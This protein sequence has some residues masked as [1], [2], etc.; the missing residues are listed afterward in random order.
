[1]YLTYR[2]LAQRLKEERHSHYSMLQKR[3]KTQWK[4]ISFKEGVPGR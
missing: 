1:M 3:I 2:V 4:L